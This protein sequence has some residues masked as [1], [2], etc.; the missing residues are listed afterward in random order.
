MEVA[1]PLMPSSAGLAT[2]LQRF[3][4]A[5]AAPGMPTR[6]MADGRPSGA[7]DRGRTRWNGLEQPLEPASAPQ[8]TRKLAAQL[9]VRE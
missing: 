4:R 6:G 1:P 7:P 5:Q 3:G 9:P 2:L 8:G